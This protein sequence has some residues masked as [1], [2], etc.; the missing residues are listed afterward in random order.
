MPQQVIADPDAA[1]AEAADKLY[2]A[3]RQS[4]YRRTDRMFALLM[5]IQFVFGIAAAAFI[6]PRTWAGTASQVHPHIWAA[7]FLGGA[8][9]SFPIILAILKPGTRDHSLC[10]FRR[11]RCFGLR[12]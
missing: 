6:S 9:S 5:A 4:V 3:H 2:Q 11:G 10:H 7:V 12:Y 1:A 8:L